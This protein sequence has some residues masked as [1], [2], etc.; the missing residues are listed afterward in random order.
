[1]VFRRGHIGRS[2]LI[3]SGVLFLCTGCISQSVKTGKISPEAHKSFDAAI[4]AHRAGENKIALKH[5]KKK[6][7]LNLKDFEKD[8][9]QISGDL[10]KIAD[11]Q[12]SLG[13]YDKSAT[14]YERALAIREKRLGATHQL[15]GIIQGKLFRIYIKLN[16]MREAEAL[17]LRQIEAYEK[18]ENPERATHL[19]AQV[20]LAK[21]YESQGRYDKAEPYFLTYYKSWE[22]KF[23][24]NYS[25]TVNAKA[26]L[27]QFYKT[28]GNNGKAETLYLEV[29]ASK[30]A[31]FG[32]NHHTTAVIMN[33]LARIY[34]GQ[35]EYAKAETFYVRAITAYEKNQGR[36]SRL[37]RAIFMSN[38]GD[39]YVAQ[40]KFDKAEPMILQA[41]AIRLR[42]LGA[43]HEDTIES[44][45]KL[46]K[47]YKAQ[48][49]QL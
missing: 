13:N 46:D 18:S 25:L 47:L 7:A 30:E 39:L 14:L 45:N 38:L 3:M 22:T 26:R 19:D 37:D 1:M 33:N 28:A 16:K 23:G 9:V 48:N 34:Q 43:D 36:T 44:L 42:E 32:L 6:L 5:A 41:F 4:A 35:D 12:W 49:D 40:D 27:A 17:Y 11:I 20:T 29:L 24:K 31:R 8:D 2:V 21:L 10:E 15:T